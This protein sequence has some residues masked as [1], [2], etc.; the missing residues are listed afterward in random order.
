MTYVDLRFTL[1]KINGRLVE[2]ERLNLILLSEVSC[3]FLGTCVQYAFRR[4]RVD[5]P[6]DFGFLILQDRAEIVR[7][8]EVI[9]SIH[10]LMKSIA[11]WMGKG[12]D[13]SRVCRPDEVRTSFYLDKVIRLSRTN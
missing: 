1:F 3:P 6:D 4:Q 10:W 12:I 7:R 9:V 5:L 2:L 13:C 11:N 8:K